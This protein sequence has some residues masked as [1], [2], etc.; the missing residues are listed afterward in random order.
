[1]SLNDT[2]KSIKDAINRAGVSTGDVIGPPSPGMTWP[3]YEQ[4]MRDTLS[5]NQA[6]NDANDSDRRNMSN[7]YIQPSKRNDQSTIEPAQI[8][9]TREL[10]KLDQSESDDSENGEAKSSDLIPKIEID[11]RTQQI[12]DRANGAGS[13]R[14]NGS[15]LWD[16]PSANLNSSGQISDKKIKESTDVDLESDQSIAAQDAYK[17]YYASLGY[18]REDS[19]TWKNDSGDLDTR[20]MS[21]ILTTT[22]NV[23]VDEMLEAYDMNP[24]AQPYSGLNLANVGD[25]LNAQSQRN[26]TDGT[27]HPEALT[28]D[29]MTGEQYEIFR[30]LTGT[31]RPVEDID[32]YGTY[33]KIEE[34]RNYGF[35]PYAPDGNDTL[36]KMH[37]QEITKRPTELAN[38]LAG[39]RTAMFDYGIN[40]NDQTYSGKDFDKNVTTYLDKIS[41]A[42]DQAQKN[43]ETPVFTDPKADHTGMTPYTHQGYVVNMDDGDPLELPG[44]GFEVLK[45]GAVNEDGTPDYNNDPSIVIRFNDGTEITFDDVYDFKDNMDVSGIRVAEKGEPE[46]AWYPDLVLD[47]GQTMS[48]ADAIALIGDDPNFEDRDETISYDYGP[49]GLG[50]PQRHSAGLLGDGVGGL[51]NNTWDLTASSVP[52][53]H[54][55]TGVTLGIGNAATAMSGQDPRSLTPEGGRQSSEMDNSDYASMIAANLAMPITEMGWGRIGKTVA[56]PFAN[57]MTQAFGNRA[58]YPGYEWIMGSVGE[59]LEELPGN[60]MED[61]ARSGLSGAFA[62]E[63]DGEYDSAGNPIL[64]RDTP[65]DERLRNFALGKENEPGSSALDAF[66][67]GGWLGSVFGLHELPS[68]IAQSR[69]NY[70]TNRQA[71]DAGVGVYRNGRKVKEG[72]EAYPL[73]EDLLKFL[74]E[75]RG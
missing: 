57:K 15:K 74:D 12:I 31:G 20:S 71:K 7:Q 29:T 41:F 21:E 50:K 67:G 24:Y 53:F 9:E 32:P 8:N 75:N 69:A 55:L 46:V 65:I 11:E 16:R 1:M 63:V 27:L 49:L 28:S 6:W 52:Y 38:A 14:D 68:T 10:F 59:G 72:A 23:S 43:G 39:S 73:N 54:P 61:I 4:S 42:Q 25:A 62:N 22:P 44:G 3:E 70:Y 30:N 17:D 51:L 58:W 45:Y 56:L 5:K 26:M 33:S 48:Y 60:A 34:A 18:N 47:S 2:I 13:Q 40:M 64:D 36:N 35:I 66:A 37:F 19:S